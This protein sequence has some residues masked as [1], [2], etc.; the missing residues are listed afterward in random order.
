[1]LD[2]ILNYDYI[3]YIIW[4]LAWFIIAFINMSIYR[5]YNSPAV[6]ALGTFAPDHEG[7][8]LVFFTFRWVIDQDDPKKIAKLKRAL[9]IM[10]LLFV[11][12]TLA[13]ATLF[14]YKLNHKTI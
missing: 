9:N 10:S 6:D 5:H 14:L 8:L 13:S 2:Y 11:L 4:A 1:M 7:N 3:L 12:L